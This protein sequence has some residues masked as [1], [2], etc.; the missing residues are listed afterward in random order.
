MVNKSNNVHGGW[1][2]GKPPFAKESERSSLAKIDDGG[3]ATKEAVVSFV[4]YKLIFINQLERPFLSGLAQNPGHSS[5]KNDSRVAV[6]G[7]N[8]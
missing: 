5:V 2:I 4:Q 3:K 6:T 7:M 8:N 1:R